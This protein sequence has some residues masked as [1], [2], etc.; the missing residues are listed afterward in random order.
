MADARSTTSLPSTIGEDNTSD[1]GK[2]IGTSAYGAVRPGVGEDVG[3]CGHENHDRVETRVDVRRG[4]T[5][6]G[7][8]VA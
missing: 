7:L 5:H 6:F 3:A 8:E 2:E 1:D 4:S